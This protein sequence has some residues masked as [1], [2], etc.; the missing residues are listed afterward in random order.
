MKLLQEARICFVYLTF[1]NLLG[2]SDTKLLQI[3][4]LIFMGID[5]QPKMIAWHSCPCWTPW[6]NSL[7]IPVPSAVIVHLP[8]SRRYL[9]QNYTFY[10]ALFL[11]GCW[12]LV[13]W[14]QLSD[15]KPLRSSVIHNGR[16]D[17]DLVHLLIINYSSQTMFEDFTATSL[18]VN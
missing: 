4:L 11:T 5:W 18:L 13:D 16:V 17:E 9:S 10:N 6:W 14:K 12:S 8:K 1:A 2:N 3:L 7:W 15:S